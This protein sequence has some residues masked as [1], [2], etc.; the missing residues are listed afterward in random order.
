MSKMP[1]VGLVLSGGGAK[2]A[3]QVGVLRALQE[4]GTR[5]DMV[6]GASIGALNGGVLAGAPNFYEGV[7]RVEKLWNTLAQS[8]P[9]KVNSM[10]YIKLL[11][12][13]GS[14]LMPGPQ[15]VRLAVGAVEAAGPVESSILSDDPLKELMDEY[16][17]VDELAKGLPL[18]VSVYKS[19]GGTND[20]GR[21]L[22]AATGLKDTPNSEFL[23][24]QSL[25]ANEQ[26]NALLASAALPMLFKAREIAGNKY[27]DGGQGGW[28]KAQGNTPITPLI[29]AGCNLIIVTHLNDGSLWSRH[30]FPDVTVLEIRPQST[31]GRATG[32]L[33]GAKDLLGFDSSKIPSWIEQGYR[34]TLHCMGRVMEAVESRGE[35][36]VSKHAVEK[37]EMRGVQADA[38]LEDIMARLRNNN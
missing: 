19:L 6:S 36:K 1:K 35:L 8:S 33:G 18:Y 22:L 21:C 7:L 32:L 26:R 12:A 34:D 38:A 28:S 13:A 30:D 2:G 37:S 20:I 10:A 23:H 14:V 17:D 3:Y 4:L 25:P 5:V 24:L 11:L 16:L 29:N 9:L 15:L 27:T 31:M